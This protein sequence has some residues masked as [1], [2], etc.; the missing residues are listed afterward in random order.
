[1]IPLA[2]TRWQV[3]WQE[4]DVKVFEFELERL[5]MGTGMMSRI[6]WERKEYV[7]EVGQKSSFDGKPEQLFSAGHVGLTVS[8]LKVKTV[9]IHDS[10]NPEAIPVKFEKGPGY[11]VPEIEKGVAAKMEMHNGKEWIGLTVNGGEEWIPN[12]IK[13]KP[14][15]ERD[16]KAYVWIKAKDRQAV[17]TKRQPLVLIDLLSSL[18]DQC[19]PCAWVLDLHA[20]FVSCRLS[21]KPK[22][23]R[24]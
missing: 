13:I 2:F 11:R 18:V 12:P 17:S 3:P 8:V 19:L 16:Q 21:I 20:I 10:T 9:T 15:E 5:F 24:P 1:M 4:G 23:Q 14:K 22:H 7:N 6:I